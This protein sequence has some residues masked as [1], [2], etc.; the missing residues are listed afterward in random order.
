VERY[1]AER[2]AEFL[3]SNAVDE[4]DYR[5]ACKEVAKLGLIPIQ[6]RITSPLRRID[7]FWTRM[8]FQSPELKQS[9]SDF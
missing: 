9:D 4:A 8:F 5:R 1:T 2:K 7:C 3:S 6:S